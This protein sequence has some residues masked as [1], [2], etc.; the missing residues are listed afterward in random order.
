MTLDIP[1]YRIIEKL[2]VGAQSRIFRARCMRTGK[3][4]AVKTVK[5]QKPEDM[6]IVDMMRAEHAIGSTVCHPNV[7]KVYELRMIRHRLRTRGAILFMEY[8]DGVPISDNQFSE[9]LDLVLGLFSQA[10]SALRAMHIA[11]FVH[12][13]LK[14]SNM[15][16][17]PD[18]KLKL[19]D[20][21]QSAKIREAKQRIQGTMDYIAPEQ[22][23]RG[24]LDER[25]DVFGLGATMHRVLTGKPIITELNQT[26]NLASPS[27][28][29]RTELPPQGGFED[30]PVSVTRF[31]VD[32]CSS[33][34]GARPADMATFIKRLDLVRTSITRE[35]TGNDLD[36]DEHG[37]DE[38][39]EAAEF[40]ASSDDLLDY[41][42]VDPPSER[43]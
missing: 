26:V 7:R 40:F 22:V 25:T 12:A 31:V 38:D 8:V 36:Q 42:D 41:I 35:A 29:R 6:S 33:D 15:L 32:C 21:G 3:D 11:G 4:Y 20:L 19:I 28:V 5:I 16:V 39:Y 27:L 2:G 34:P 17:T 10:A 18:L 24:V 37:L 1:N 23:Q 43:Q 13:D 30:L 14:P 9:S